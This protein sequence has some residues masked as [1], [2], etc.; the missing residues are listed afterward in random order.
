MSTP[1]PTQSSML[2]QESIEAQYARELNPAQLEAVTYCD[3][4]SLVI[5]GA[6]SGKTRV[7]TYK[8]AYLLEK[9]VEPWNILALTFTNKAAN[10]MN[11][12]IQSICGGRDIHALQSGTFHSIFARILRI[13][14]E[15]ANLPADY[16][17]YDSAD[18]RSLIKAIVKELEL[19]EKKYKPAVV[20]GRIS[21]AKNHLILPQSYCKDQNIA[22]RDHYDNLGETGKIYT[23]Y[24]TR[25]RQAGALDF[26]DLLLQTYLLLHNNATIR[27]HYQTRF[28]Y[29]LVDEYQDTNMAQHRILAELTRPDSCIC[30]VG[31][32]AQSI[33]G[34]RG[35]DINN[36]LQFTRQYPSARLI[37]LE[38]NYRS[39]QTIVEA[40]NSIIRHNAGQIPKKFIPQDRKVTPFAYFPLIATK[41]KPPRSPQK[42]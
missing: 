32:D 8:I 40:A 33:Y 3:G 7:L 39:T 16:S 1:I 9:G 29:I 15:M 2:L 5:A 10:E 30:V 36:I 42:S 13:E 14:H 25:L 24:Q 38:C 37:K 11:R 17:I 4:P 18:S 26:D 27:Q 41:K 31:D 20:A 6:G 34:F 28:R 23:I 22:R 12:R 21:E 35:A 19:D